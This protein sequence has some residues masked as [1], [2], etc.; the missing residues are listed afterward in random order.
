[1]IDPGSENQ[2]SGTFANDRE[3]VLCG[4]IDKICGKPGSDERMH[5]Y[6]S[7]SA[8]QYACIGFPDAIQQIFPVVVADVAGIHS[9]SF[10]CETLGVLQ[11]ER[12]PLTKPGCGYNHDKASCQALPDRQERIS[13]L[14][15]RR[16]KMQ[17]HGEMWLF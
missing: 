13:G 11:G 15:D 12:T 10:C 14:F 6:K 2:R 3:G 5:Q 8:K 16:H 4:A 7:I 17:F 9:N 1:M